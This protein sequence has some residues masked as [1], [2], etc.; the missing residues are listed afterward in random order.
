MGIG[1]TRCAREV[2]G[3]TDI[4]ELMGIGITRCAREVEDRQTWQ[5]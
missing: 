1:I 4:A 2:E 3:L 5:S